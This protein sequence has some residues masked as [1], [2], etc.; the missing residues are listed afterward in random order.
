MAIRYR[1]GWAPDTFAVLRKSAH[2]IIFFGLIVGKESPSSCSS[3]PCKSRS[4]QG[5]VTQRC[6][7]P[8]KAWGGE[9]K[10]LQSTLASQFICSSMASRGL[11]WDTFEKASVGGIILACLHIMESWSSPDGLL[12]SYKYSWYN[13]NLFPASEWR[14]WSEKLIGGYH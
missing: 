13:H 11:G 10:V 6:G 8:E 2:D 7:S 12:F 14:S 9:N 5:D 4:R 1:E 3:S